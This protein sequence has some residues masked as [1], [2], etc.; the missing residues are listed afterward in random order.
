M[1]FIL[2]QG[3]DFL[4]DKIAS[5]HK[6]TIIESNAHNSQNNRHFNRVKIAKKD[7]FRLRIKVLC[8]DCT[9]VL[10]EN[11]TIDPSKWWQEKQDEKGCQTKGDLLSLFSR[12]LVWYGKQWGPYEIMWEIFSLPF[13]PGKREQN[14][15]D[16]YA[17]ILEEIINLQVKI[18]SID[19]NWYEAVAK[20][21]QV[22]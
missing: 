2:T 16:I 7:Y 8:K 18:A 6:N 9:D 3:L 19:K 14:L 17:L 11:H 22:D 1:I 12:V 13:I 15:E 10:M 20:E 5:S 4:R 21:C